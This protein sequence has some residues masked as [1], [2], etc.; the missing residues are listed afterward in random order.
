MAR[1]ILWVRVAFAASEE[2]GAVGDRV[3][4]ELF[5]AVETGVGDGGADIDDG[6]FLDAAGVQGANTG[7]Q[8][9]DQA[10]VDVGECDDAL[11]SNAVLAGGLKH[12]THEDASDALEV[13]LRDVIEDNGGVFAAELDAHRRQ[14]FGSRGADVVGDGARADEGDVR[15]GRVGGQVVGNIWPADD[16]L[17]NVGGVAAYFEGFGCDGGKV[18]GGP[19]GGFGTFDDDGIAGEDGGDDGADEVVELDL[20]DFRAFQYNMWS[21]QDSWYMSVVLLLKGDKTHFQLTQAA[22]TPSGSHMT[23]FDLYIIKKFVSRFSLFKLFSPCL[24][25]HLSFSTVTKISPRLASTIV[26]P[27]SRHAILAIVSWLLRINL[28]IVLSTLRR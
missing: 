25:V 3:G 15:Y 21:L 18:V 27:E 6:L 4:D 28:S 13:A 12:A 9:V 10:V 7:G 11:N 2:A 24:I 16:G 1:G 22:T 5:Q 19:G 14:G 8:E 20:L 23:S 26:L 17:D